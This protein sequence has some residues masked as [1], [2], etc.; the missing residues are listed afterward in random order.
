M[1]VDLRYPLPRGGLVVRLWKSYW[2][3][4]KQCRPL[5]ALHNAWKFQGPNGGMNF[6]RDVQTKG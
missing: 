5:A 2:M 1:V 4:Q 3:W 6:I